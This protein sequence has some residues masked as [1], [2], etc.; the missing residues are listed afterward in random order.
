MLAVGAGLLAIP[1]WRPL[2]FP[3]WPL[4][5]GLGLAGSLGQH[6]ITE[7]FRNAPVSVVT[8]LEYTAL[9]W[10]MVLD[11]SI[12][13]VLPDA[14]TLVGGAIVVGAGLYVIRRAAASRAVAGRGNFE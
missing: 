12:W 8:P 11:F 9:V 14:A 7:A 1:D 3:D 10:G 5:V 4:L 2:Q 6:F 13:N